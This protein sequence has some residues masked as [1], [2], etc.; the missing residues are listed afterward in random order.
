[1]SGEPARGELERRIVSVLFCDLAGFTALSERLDP[2]D[3]ATVQ[4]AYFAAVREAVGRHGGTL[5]KFIGDAAVAVYGVPVAGEDDAERAV[6]TGLAIAGA[7]ERLAASLGLDEHPLHVRV[8]VNTGEAVVHPAPAPGEALVTGDVVNTAARLQAA[9]PPGGVLV[10]PQTALAVAHSVELAPAGSL[11]LKGKAAPVAASRALAVLSE[12]DREQA[13]GELR[14]PTVGRARELAR[15]RDVV[16]SCRSGGSLRLTVVAPPGTG[17][18]RLLQELA[19]LAEADGLVVRSARVRP[20]ALAAFRPVADLAASALAAAGH[21]DDA[22]SA[23]ALLAER[24]GEARAAVVVD[25]LATLLAGAAAGGEAE[26]EARRN[27][28]FAA[29]SDALAALGAGPE[30]WLVEDVHWSSPDLRAFLHAAGNGVPGRLLVS[31]SRPS[32]LEEDAEWVSAGA[33]LTLEP[34]AEPATAELV[35]ALVGP[36]LPDDLVAAIAERSRGNPL[37]V[38]ELLRSWAATGLLAPSGGGAW[39]LTRAADEVVLPATVQAVYA[40]QLDDLP[41]EARR[42]VR[43]ASVA[44]RQFPLAAVAVLEAGGGEALQALL[45]RD[46]VRGPLTDPVLGETYVFR[47]ALLRDVGYAS[48]SRAERARLHGRLA[49]WLAGRAEAHPHE[50]AAL[51]GRHFAAAL[52]SAPMLAGDLGDGLTRDAAAEGAG[53]WLETAAD[54]ALAA[55]AFQSAGELYREALEHAG[56]N[57]LSRARRLLGLARATAFTSD[58]ATGLDAAEEALALL[59][60]LARDGRASREEAAA[61]A[62]TV[63]EIYVQQL[64]FSAAMELAADVLHEL[65]DA[66]DAVAVR[67]LLLQIRGAAM[68]SDEAWAAVEAQRRRVARLAPVL[69]D[70]ELRLQARM[71]VVWDEEDT[72][73]AWAE[74]ERLA[75]ELGR[76]SDV[77]EA[78]SMLASLCLPDDLEGVRAAAG[79]LASFAEAHGLREARSWASYY[80]CE[81]AF[82][83]GDWEEVLSAG[84]RA[85][86][87]AEA[88]SFHRAAARTWFVLVPVAAARGEQ[89]LLERAWAWYAALDSFP[90][91]PYGRLSRTAVDVLLASAG[92]ES[93]FRVPLAELTPSLEEGGH[94]PSWLEA[95][96]VVLRDALA[97]GAVEPARRAVETY[98]GAHARQPTESGAAALALLEARLAAADGDDAGLR[99]RLETLRAH[100]RPWPLLKALRLLAGAGGAT[101]AELAEA[102]PLASRLG[103]GEGR[104][105][106]AAAPR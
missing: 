23:S 73:A 48:L 27:A 29:W 8:G 64:R 22:R 37:F 25:E 90:D 51:V 67:L 5:E 72:R 40:A 99:E 86:D 70:P 100:G 65:G 3:A 1:M 17:K 66:D 42:L 92:L 11:E 15:L 28:R 95:V 26:S 52:A 35:Q 96:D 36:A 79:R 7:V 77:V 54:A 31:T 13:M 30:A 103:L 101:P 32:L 46:A 10:G 68:I 56:A 18:T 59:R 38:E 39:R 47:H 88:G 81:A 6:R 104:A 84:R 78:R 43:R 63:G 19:R 41:A 105:A 71:G 55:A 62:A 82:A 58:M 57:E 60:R 98:R 91:S 83:A 34:L 16:A 2:E 45:R 97:A 85:L 53:R 14:A 33:V 50:L 76:W 9:A 87:L 80:A 4:Q 74:I 12:P 94:L 93:T 21:P 75:L 61:A 20:D 102:G 24:L 106:A 49:R 89:G 44:G 69:A